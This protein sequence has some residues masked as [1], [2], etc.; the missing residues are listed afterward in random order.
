[1]GAELSLQEEIPTQEYLPEAMALQRAELN[2][3]SENI[4][5]LEDP[6]RTV[7]FL[8]YY[9]KMSYREIG[10]Y[11]HKSNNWVK[12]MISRAKEQLRQMLKDSR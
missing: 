4:W 6:M 5:K 12:H 7:I 11:L 10:E 1:M 9:D 3:I 8:K 2:E